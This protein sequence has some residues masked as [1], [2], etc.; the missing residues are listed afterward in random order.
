M[1]QKGSSYISWVQPRREKL[2][3]GRVAFPGT[4]SISQLTISLEGYPDN[5]AEPTPWVDEKLMKFW[6]LKMLLGAYSPRKLSTCSVFHL[7]REVA[8]SF[9]RDGAKE[10][11]CDVEHDGK[12]P[13]GVPRF[14]SRLDQSNYTLVM[15][16]NW[17]SSE[18]VHIWRSVYI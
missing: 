17:L 10:Y 13:A 16:S 12:R 15:T 6:T 4:F 3:P 1:G 14:L 2:F 9:Y 11:E 5:R 8:A 18:H 7:S